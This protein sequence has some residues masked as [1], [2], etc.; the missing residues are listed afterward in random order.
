LF[1]LIAESPSTW[2]RADSA[3]PENRFP[4]EPVGYF[5]CQRSQAR[6]IINNKKEYRIPFDKLRAGRRQNTVEPREIWQCVS[7][8]SL[9]N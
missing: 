1:L 3:N 8:G 6:I 5:D 9:K 7:R 2:L 4:D